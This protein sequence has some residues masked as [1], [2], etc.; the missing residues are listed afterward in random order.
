M[1]TFIRQEEECV[2][3]TGSEL[4]LRARGRYAHARAKAKKRVK[5]LLARN[6][7]LDKAVGVAWF[8]DEITNS[9]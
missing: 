5:L 7:Y 6:A 8:V 3:D 1:T 9:E 4:A 2:R